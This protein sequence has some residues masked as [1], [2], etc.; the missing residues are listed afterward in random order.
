V[1]IEES[2]EVEEKKKESSKKEKDPKK[3]AKL[4]R[5]LSARVFGL[6]SPNKEKGKKEAEL[7]PVAAEV[8]DTC[9]PSAVF[10][11]LEEAS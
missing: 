9:P 7:A 10:R 2:K 4:A 1:K 11:I 5:R 3:E 8:G 6:I